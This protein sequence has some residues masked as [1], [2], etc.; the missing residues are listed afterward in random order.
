MKQ[1]RATVLLIILLLGLAVSGCAGESAVQPTEPTDEVTQ[2]VTTEPE[3]LPTEA[4]TEAPTEPE[5]QFF[6]PLTGEGMD[7]P[8]EKRIVSISIGNT[9][10]AMPT[11]GLTQ[12]DI[13]F[14]MY[15]NHMITRLLALYT[16]PTDVPAIGSIRSHRYHFTD[17]AVSYDTIAAHAGG[18]N[19]VMKD[20][21]RSGVDHMNI[22]TGS[23]TYYS[24]RDGTRKSSG[25]LWEH[26]LF[27]NGAGLY[28]Y[29]E[30]KGYTTA[31]DSEKD[32][33]LRFAEGAALTDGETANTVTLTFQL[34]GH[35]K[36]T[37]MTFNPDTGCY[38]FSQ[39]GM[40]MIDGNNGENVAFRNVFVILANTWTD[41]DAYQ[42]SNILGSG[43]GFFACDGYLI[44]IRWV[45]QTDA[46]VFTFTHADG[47]P[48]EQGVGSSYIAIAPLLSSVTAE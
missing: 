41:D 47:T 44:P 40:S 14:E 5:P 32:Y 12:A 33:G 30:S 26:C 11:Y 15:V 48:L 38:E 17:I 8:Q 46:D 1:K 13:V 37:V 3:T 45:R 20:A 42:V 9:Y 19:I 43:D 29:A 7:A 24:F 35:S 21:N 25:Y 23:S 22:D 2:P 36:T 39:Y 6:N 34:S 27:A 10:D 31:F 28:D 18:S 4:P 16:D